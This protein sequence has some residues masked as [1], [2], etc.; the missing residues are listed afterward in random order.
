M[1]GVYHSGEWERCDIAL[2][3]DINKDAKALQE[4]SKHNDQHGVKKRFCVK[5][6]RET[7]LTNRRFYSV[8]HVRF[9]YVSGKIPLQ[10]SRLGF[11]S[12]IGRS[13]SLTQPL[14]L[15]VDGLMPD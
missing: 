10:A 3:I 5:L 14:C 11:R 9:P 2:K 12:E 1:L 7:S 6:S 15:K 4:L 13:T 8:N